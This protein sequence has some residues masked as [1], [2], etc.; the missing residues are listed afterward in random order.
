[1]K[2]RRTITVSITAEQDDLLRACLTSGRYRSVSEA[3]RAALRL[4]E[5]DEAAFARITADRGLAEAA[6]HA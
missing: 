2:P 4:L 1:M 3:M 5:R 6:Q